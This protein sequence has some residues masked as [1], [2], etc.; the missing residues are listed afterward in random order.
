MDLSFISTS[1]APQAVGPYSQAVQVGKWVFL[2]GQISIDPATQELKLYEGD[3]AK[4]TKRV[5]ENIRAIL[6]SQGMTMKQV[7]KT[8]IFLKDMN[9]FGKVN[10]VYAEAFG[11]HRPARSCVAVSGLPKGVSVEIESI[12][13]LN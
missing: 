1:A 2:S 13:V 7:V 6:S 9:D 5:L 8:S 12:A 10:E 11:D 3:V 4:Q